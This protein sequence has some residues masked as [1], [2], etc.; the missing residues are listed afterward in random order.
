MMGI[1]QT[2]SHTECR[3]KYIQT[4]LKYIEFRMYVGTYLSILL[5]W[6]LPYFRIDFSFL[7]FCFYFVLIETK[8]NMRQNEW[9]T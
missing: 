5:E 3:V 4:D 6:R 2:D 1:T 9:K 7:Y 8:H